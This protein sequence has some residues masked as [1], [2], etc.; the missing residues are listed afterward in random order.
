[1][2]RVASMNWMG[3]GNGKRIVGSCIVNIHIILALLTF[4]I[5]ITADCRVYGFS[6]L[7]QYVD[8]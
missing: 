6:N 8:N 3:G 7:D 4:R 1:M 2:R 5:D